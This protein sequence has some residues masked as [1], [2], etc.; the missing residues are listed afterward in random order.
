MTEFVYDRA[1]SRVYWELTRACALACRHCRAEAIPGR[2]GRELSFAE[3]CRLL[4]ALGGFGGRGPSVVLSGGDPL[5]RPDVWE[6]LHAGAGL[7]LDMAV[8]PSGTPSLAPAAV[9][10]LARSGARAISLS[11]DGPDA[12]AHD[13][14]RGVP[15]CF[16]TVRNHGQNMFGKLSLHSRLEAAAYATRHGVLPVGPPPAPPA[17]AGAPR[18]D[19][20]R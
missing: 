11:V 6:L 14:F 10:R 16:A 20:R 1:P 12:A 8:S 19:G 5:E 2:A 15:G 4:E 7:G 17:P 18:E 13:G 3:E 9:G